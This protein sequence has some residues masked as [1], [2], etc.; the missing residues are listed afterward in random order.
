[1]QRA[2]LHHFILRRKCGPSENRKGSVRQ[3]GSHRWRAR[4]LGGFLTSAVVV[5]VVVVSV[6]VFVVRCRLL[7]RESAGPLCAL[8]S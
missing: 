1:M 6:V 5:V 8:F 4:R 7:T 2:F 3:R